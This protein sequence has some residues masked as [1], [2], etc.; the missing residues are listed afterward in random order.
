MWEGNS[1]FYQHFTPAGVRAHAKI[2]LIN[3]SL[4]EL[5]FFLFLRTLNPARVL[6]LKPSSYP[7]IAIRHQNFIPL[8]IET[9]KIFL[10]RFTYS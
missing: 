3:I 1:F 8:F 10:T 2:F 5:V 7:C 6:F 9:L 4:R